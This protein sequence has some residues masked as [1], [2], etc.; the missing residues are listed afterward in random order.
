M[1]ERDLFAEQFSFE[2]VKAEAD[3]ID[4]DEPPFRILRPSPHFINLMCFF[5][6]AVLDVYVQLA[7]ELSTRLRIAVPAIHKEIVMVRSRPLE[8]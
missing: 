4:K 2:F 3:V 6:N 7:K 8:I 5:H 1:S